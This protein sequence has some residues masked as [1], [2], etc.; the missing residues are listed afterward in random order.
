MDLEFSEEQEAIQGMTRALLQEHATIEIVRKMEDDPKGY[1]D[2]LWKQMSES[3]LVGMLIPE[4][5]GGGG[6]TLLE[7]ARVYEEIGRA[8]GPIPQSEAGVAAQDCER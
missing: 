8:M 1:P 7:A 2:A 4:N 3:G 6:L 5:Y